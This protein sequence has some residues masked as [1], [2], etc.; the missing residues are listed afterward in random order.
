L[1]I[2]EVTAV[3]VYGLTSRLDI[4]VAVPFLH[5]GLS[6]TSTATVNTFERA[7]Y[8]SDPTADPY[9]C[10][11]NPVPGVTGCMN[12][13]SVTTVP[14]EKLLPVTNPL[15][16]HNQAIFTSAGS[17]FGIGDVIFRGK[18]QA[19]KR[20][21]TGLAI[22][23]DLHAPT[24][25]ETQFLGS[26]TWGA[27]PF[28]AFSYSGR[29]SPHA[30]LGYQFNGHS[31]LAANLAT[32]PKGHLPN[33]VTYD[34]GLDAGVRSWVSVSADFLGQSLRGVFKT[35][36][37]VFPDTNGVSYTTLTPGG[38]YVSRNQLSFAVG[39]KFKPV[40]KLIVSADVLFRL[41]EPGLHSRPVP[42]IG[43]S[44]RF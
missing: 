22:G 3:A 42:L 36:Q 33:V 5:V 14:G 25:A 44:Y 16:G 11:N 15:L 40:G 8:E 37:I 4:S 26:G 1:K 24:G 12:Q 17:A 23:L 38:G 10:N 31:V 19:I 29:I 6:M 20:E 2:H 27:R 32:G 9:S 43:V 34:V 39:G 13:F 30:S 18:L 21:R 41:D 28:A 7:P 35:E